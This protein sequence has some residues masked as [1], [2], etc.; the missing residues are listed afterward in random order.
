[1]KAPLPVDCA[2]KNGRAMVGTRPHHESGVA[3]VTT[4]IVVA[5]LAVV[6][7]ALMQST[8]ADRASS[9][10]VANY[11]RAQ[12]AAEAGAGM[13]GALLAS[14]MTND[15][16]IVVANTNGQLFVG[17]GSNQP[18]GSFAYTPVFSTVT[19]ITSAVTPIISAVM[20]STNVSGGTNLS[21]T[22]LPGGLAVTSPAVSWVYLTESNSIT[23][24][25]TNARFAFWVEDLS[26]KVDLSVV[27]TNTADAAARRP[28]G[29]NP[30]EIALW[31]VFSSNAVSATASGGAGNDLI[32]ARSSLITPATA[33][34]ASS[35]VTTNILASLAA[36]LR[37][38]TNEPEIIPFGFGYPDAGKPK[39]NLNTNISPAGVSS[40]GGI[41]SAN[42][43]G[44]GSRGGAMNSSAY[45]TNIAASIVD[46]ADAGDVPTA[47]DPDD[48]TYFGIE[49]IPWPNE[50]FDAIK[51]KNYVNGPPA[52][53]RIQLKDFV[54]V[55]NM[56][57]KA[58]AAGTS[59]YISNSY[60]L[61][62]TFTNPMIPNGVS[63]GVGFQQSLKDLLDVDN[64]NASDWT[65]FRAF[66]LPNDL[67]PNGYAVLDSDKAIN[68]TS[69]R[70]LGANIPDPNWVAYAQTNAGAKASWR[71][72]IPK[73]TETGT[74]TFRAKSGGQVVQK[75]TGRWPG[76]I[77]FENT[78]GL[79]VGGSPADTFIFGNPIGFA[80]QTASSSAGTVPVHSGGDPRAQLFLS[81][82]LRAQA[83][84]NPS[85][86]S[87]PGGR[88]WEKANISKFPESEVN[89]VQYWPD[90][91]HT[92]NSD[93]GS[94]ATSYGDAPLSFSVTPVTNNWVMFRNDTGTFS[95][96]LELG[97]IYDPL[98]WSDQSGS[99]VATQP[100][101]WTNLTT[102]ARP[103]A[104][105]GGRN[106]LRVGRWE[107][108]KFNTNGQRASQ[109][110]DLF[111]VG[112]SGG[113]G[114][115]TNRI[116]GRI[117]INTASTNVLRALAA[118]VYHS[119]DP[120]LLALSTGGTNF[121]VAN[122]AVAS[123]ITGVANRTAQKPFFS[124]AEL[125]TLST[126]TNTTGWP[127]SAVFGN[128][129]VAGVK[130]WNDRAVEEW[131]AKIYPLATVRSRNFLVYAVGQALQPGTTNVVSTA[132]SVFQVY[133]R[134]VR[135]ANGVATNC[136][137][138]V[139]Q[140]WS[141]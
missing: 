111:A 32:S 26:G 133:I 93:R 22:N 113:S 20:P 55:W 42:L 94:N 124:A 137:P 106:T 116:P 37:H 86:Y 114:P 52:Q 78:T 72:L 65:S 28:T 57:N 13:A 10:S 24:V 122:T 108:S 98:Q 3:L 1:M 11:T 56:G 118:G 61:M 123:F 66:T 120:A 71:V 138:V 95:N 125:S 77:R 69:H 59:I 40:I 139:V 105:F 54:E 88:N 25:R 46:Y 87:S 81:A 85:G 38:D 44:F 18:A 140:S 112:P 90:S 43:P 53:I 135:G 79:Q 6:A 109:L 51:F 64:G 104:R 67:P 117:N 132:K 97:N 58:I 7:V 50:L 134:P 31:A 110:L 17:N 101:L 73:E 2:P 47:D 130:E 39:Y 63:A 99:G 80:S 8:T 121:V 49:N 60:D 19:S 34:L 35:N 119:S 14:Q 91:G 136:S 62:L 92:N 36:N 45:V 30:A 107:F 41:I 141:L 82:A 127:A 23:G 75:S 128:S 84:N 70:T 74:M 103:D 33:R 115:V 89:P 15:H 102:A 29:T 100:G 27:G 12:L 68:G 21:I 9:R 5:M 83:Y 96:I 4:V 48:P 16:F 129:N 131:F 126:N 76:Y